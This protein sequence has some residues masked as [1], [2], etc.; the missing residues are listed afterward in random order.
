MALMIKEILSKTDRKE[1]N[2]YNQQ[3]LLQEIF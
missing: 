2:R 1:L 3:K